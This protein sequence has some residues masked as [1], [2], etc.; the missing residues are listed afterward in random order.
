MKISNVALHVKISDYNPPRLDATLS[1]PNFHGVMY[2]LTPPQKSRH[3]ITLPPEVLQR[4]ITITR[5]ERFLI[6]FNWFGVFCCERNIENFKQHNYLVRD[7]ILFNQ[8]FA[9]NPGR[10]CSMNFDKRPPKAARKYLPYTDPV[11]GR[12]LLRSNSEVAT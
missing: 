10:V 12:C 2:V 9:I 11:L 6:R 8:N 3:R 1:N 7:F 4:I 5:K